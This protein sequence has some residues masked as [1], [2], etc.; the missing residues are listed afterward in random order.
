MRRSLMLPVLCA[1]ALLP[2][3]S[4]AGPFDDFD[5]AGKDHGTVRDN[6]DFNFDEVEG[7]L[8]LR[9]YDALTGKPIQ[10]GR[11]TLGEETATTDPTGK[12][13]FTFP[14]IGREEGDVTAVFERQG[15]ITSEIRIHIILDSVF[16]H[17]YSISPTLP[18][19]RYRVVLDW[20]TSPADLDLHLVKQGRY[21]ISYRDMRKYE[22]QAWL[23]RDDTDGEG[24]ETVTLARLDLA[25]AYTCYVH[26]YTHRA[27]SGFQ[28]FGKSRARVMVFND[29]GLV[30]SFEVAPGPGRV[31]RVF[32]IRDA[33]IQPASQM[34][35]QTE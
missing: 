21:H 1:L 8:S 25:G 16:L 34:Q 19:G 18:A 32:E 2:L 23:D 31:W 11:V 22:D 5:E 24:P 29:H 6:A 17:R 28:E 3:A 15:Y 20:G 26:D 9:F 13:M 35:D 14:R 30:Q 33:Q 12:A 10:G 4:W 27:D 7:K